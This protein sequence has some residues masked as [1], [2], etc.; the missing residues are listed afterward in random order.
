[1]SGSEQT[2]SMLPA[3]HTHPGSWRMRIKH[4]TA[5][6]Y[7]APVAASYNEARLTP[8]AINGQ[9]VITSRIEVKPGTRLDSYIDYWGTVVHAFDVQTSHSELSITSTSLVD[10]VPRGGVGADVEWAALADRTVTDR[11]CEYLGPSGPVSIGPELADAVHEV[12][13]APNPSAAVQVVLDVVTSR[14]TYKQGSTDVSS[15]DTQ[16]WN[17]REGVCQDYSHVAIALLRGAG[18]PARYASGYLHPGK[19]DIGATVVGESHA[20]VEAWLGG[21]KAYDPTNRRPVGERHVLVGL[22]RDYTDVPPLKGI[23]SGGPTKN[24]TVSV[25]L[26]RLTR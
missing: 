5:L 1:V 16:A 12:R 6:A 23:F 13:A 3:E 21:W 4:H 26:T 8:S 22:G 2:I 19:G 10:T 17:I 7:E 14:L 25:E 20:W 15:T 9:L 24:Q 18:I 11:W